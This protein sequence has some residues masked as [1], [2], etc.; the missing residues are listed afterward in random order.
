MLLKAPHRKVRRAIALLALPAAA[1][2][3]LPVAKPLLA[4]TA[5]V[6]TAPARP[7]RLGWDELGRAARAAV[8]RE[9]PPSA[10]PFRRAAAGD[11]ARLVIANY[12]PVFPLSLDWK[13][14]DRDYYALEYLRPEGERGKHRKSQGYLRVRPLPV[15]EAA[16]HATDLR[17]FNL[18]VEVARAER[19]GIDAFGAD[20]FT[21]AP[22]QNNLWQSSIDLLDAAAAVSP[23]FR[24]VPQPDVG[25]LVGAGVTPQAVADGLMP[26]ARHRAALRT[27]DGKLIVMPLLAD[28]APLAWTRTLKETMEKRGV[29]VALVPVLL[30]PGKLPQ[31]APLS[32]AGSV[33]GGRHAA[34]GDYNLQWLRLARRSRYARWYMPV[35]MQDYRPKDWLL[36]EARNSEGLRGQWRA[37]IEQR[38][39]A[40]HL[41]TWNDYSEST[42][43]GPVLPGNFSTYDLN[44]YYIAWYKRGAPPRITRDVLYWFHRPQIV[45]SVPPD[46]GPRLTVRPPTPLAND[47]ELV[48]LLTGPGELELQTGT[49]RTRR[50]VGAGLQVLRA[51]AAPGDVVVRLRRAGKLVVEAKSATPIEARPWRQDATYGGGSSARP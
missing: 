3:A 46:G 13:P 50:T 28:I 35:S 19:I 21:V 12:L 26:F 32:W 14:A 18:A 34:A 7:A 11:S 4:Q 29:P 24:I 51:P 41:L 48:A 31:Y 27:P 5:Q 9:S 37:A 23:R 42:Q 45:T 22:D 49:Q 39:P 10:F 15:P 1:L 33:W 40:V 16:N 47:V 2:P 44:A 38:V 6:Q 30:E 20:L 25:T 36:T 43:L 17:R 8:A